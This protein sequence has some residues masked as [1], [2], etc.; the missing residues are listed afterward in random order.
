MAASLSMNQGVFAIVDFVVKTMSSNK[1]M[2]RAEWIGVI[3]KLL[4]T[5]NIAYIV[6]VHAVQV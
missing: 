3:I 2:A 1:V 4:F 5:E 6:A